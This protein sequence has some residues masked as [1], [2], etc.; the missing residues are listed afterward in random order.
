MTKDKRERRKP[1]MTQ[2]FF[3]YNKMTFLFYFILVISFLI[4][5]K[6]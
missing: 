2:Q 6:Q 3:L 4:F 1:K 5:Y